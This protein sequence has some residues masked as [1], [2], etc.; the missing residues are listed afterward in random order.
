MYEILTSNRKEE[1]N[2]SLKKVLSILNAHFL[3]K[4]IQQD[5][6]QHTTS[7]LNKDTVQHVVWTSTLKW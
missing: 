5:L 3:S 6:M 2:I 1:K 7:I 4:V